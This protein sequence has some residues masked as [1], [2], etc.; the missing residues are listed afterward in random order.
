MKTNTN[1][2]NNRRQKTTMEMMTVM[3][4]M[5]DGDNNRR[6]RMEMTTGDNDGVALI[7]VL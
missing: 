1:G 4:T 7:A 3:E 2:D 6:R 5:M